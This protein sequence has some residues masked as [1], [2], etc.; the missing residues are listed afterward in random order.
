MYQLVSSM[1]I[2]VT[3][4]K[5]DFEP[6][7]LELISRA[8]QRSIQSDDIERASFSY[9]PKGNCTMNVVLEFPPLHP[10]SEPH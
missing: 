6:M 7:L 1:K 4:A 10:S 2:Q 5:E 9:D 8:M 3:L